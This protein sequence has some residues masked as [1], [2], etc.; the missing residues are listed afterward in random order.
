MENTI[1]ATAAITA[2]ADGSP[3]RD[4]QSAVQNSSSTATL[5]LALLW[6][7][8]GLPLLWGMVKAL[9]EGNLFP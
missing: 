5:K 6:L 3:A 1:T 4:A 2:T 9:Q 7:A 8:V